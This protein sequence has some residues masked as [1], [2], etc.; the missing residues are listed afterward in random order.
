MGPT[1]MLYYAEA[2]LEVDG[3]I[4]ITGSHNPAEYNGFKMVLQHKPFFG[5]DI[6]KLGTM[7]AEG[8]WDEGAGEVSSAETVDRYVVR[9]MVGYGGGAYRIGWGIGG[10][11]WRGRACLE[12]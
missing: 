8:D 7:A 4:Q 5:D 6:Q 10:A 12:G 1:P 9:R 2:T 11:P 3:G